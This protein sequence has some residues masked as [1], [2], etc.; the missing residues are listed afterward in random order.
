MVRDF[1]EDKVKASKANDVDMIEAI[2]DSVHEVWRD[3]AHFEP[4]GNVQ[5]RLLIGSWS[6]DNALRFTVVSGAAVRSG[7]QIEAMGIGDATFLGMADRCLPRGFISPY[8]V[9]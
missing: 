7:R 3:Y 1:I 4:G 8:I 6:N 9:G 2:R 5:L